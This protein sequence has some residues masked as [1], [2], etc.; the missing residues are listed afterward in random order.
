MSVDPDD[1]DEIIA[2]I[3]RKYL[4]SIKK[5]SEFDAAQR[6]STGS[7]ELDVAMGGG[8][9]IGRWSRLYGGYSSTKTLTTLITIAEAQKMGLTCAYYNIEKQ[10]DP[11]FARDKLGVDTEKLIVVDGTTVEEITEKMEA[12]FGVVHVHVIDSCTMAVS[13]DELNADIRDW[14]PGITA[15]AWGK[16]FRRLNER[17]DTGD[18]TVVMIDQTR[19]NFKTGGEDPAGGRILGFQSSM[20]AS[21]K[22]GSWLWRNA[23]GYLDEKAKQTK[24][25]SGQVE[26]DGMEIKVRVE[27]SR[28]CRPLRTATMRLDLGTDTFGFDREFELSK[29]AKYYGV[30]ETTSVGRYEYNGHKMHGEKPLRELIR[31]DL[32]LQEEIRK[33]ALEAGQR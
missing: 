9:P 6:I 31:G 29:A 14:R 15:R 32:T 1:L 10:Y 5:G 7:L 20:S 30:V 22:K 8:I 3:N 24:G 23:E 28:V 21:F 33:T 2:K 19:V 16:G 25:S 4:G 13:E 26:P 11:D 27:K 12:L 17:F 18:N